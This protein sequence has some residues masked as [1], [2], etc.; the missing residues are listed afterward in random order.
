MKKIAS[1]IITVLVTVFVNGCATTHPGANLPNHETFN[2]HSIDEIQ[3][4]LISAYLSSD[5][6]WSIKN[7]SQNSLTFTK[8]NDGMSGIFMQSMVSGSSGALPIIE[9]QFS[10]AKLS[11]AVKI[12]PKVRIINTNGF[13]RQQ[14]TNV[15]NP[16]GAKQSLHAIKLKMEPIKNSNKAIEAISTTPEN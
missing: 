4:E 13:G 10:F 11:D 7:Q 2:N 1:L 3:S 8:V 5:G 14:V 9:C 15:D 12:Y 16:A 6:E